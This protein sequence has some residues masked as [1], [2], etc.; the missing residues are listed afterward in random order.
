MRE[1]AESG[2][3]TWDGTDTHGSRVPPGLY[4]I[5]LRVGETVDRGRIVLMD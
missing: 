1:A 2:A 5:E 4:F 3:R